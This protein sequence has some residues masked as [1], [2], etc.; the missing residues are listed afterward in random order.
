MNAL[1]GVLEQ[2]GDLMALLQS[3]IAVNHEVTE[4]FERLDNARKSPKSEVDED[5]HLEP[6]KLVSKKSKLSTSVIVAA[7]RYDEEVSGMH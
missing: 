2:M 4:V 1:V 3:I 6:E 7:F 5:S